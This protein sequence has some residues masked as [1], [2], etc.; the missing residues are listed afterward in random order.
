MTR[1]TARVCSISEN[2]LP[3]TPS[4][5]PAGTRTSVK[6]SSPRMCG[7]IRSSPRSMLS[8]GVLAGTS[9]IDQPSSSRTRVQ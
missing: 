2:A 1:K 7:A 3:G 4:R 9:T 8:P 6:V 5:L